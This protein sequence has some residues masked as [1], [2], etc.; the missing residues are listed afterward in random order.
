M[1]KQPA[2]ASAAQ[3]KDAGNALFAKKDYEAAND[4]YTEALKLDENNAVLYANRSAC[5]YN[6][7]RYLDAASDANR[8]TELDPT[9]AKAWSRLAAAYAAIGNEIASA[10]CWKKALNALPTENLTPGEKKQKDQYESEL[11][12]MQKKADKLNTPIRP[13]NG[14]PVT[15]DMAPWIRAVMMYPGMKERGVAESSAYVI[16]GA[17]HDWRAGMDTMNNQRSLEFT[18]GVL[19]SRGP[20]GAV[21]HFSNAILRDA[22]IFHLPD[23]QWLDTYREQSLAE[24]RTYRAWT[25]AGPELVK[26]EALERLEREGW[27]SLRPALAV[28]IRTWIFRGFMDSTVRGRDDVGVEF[29]GR[30][31]EI[32]RWGQEVWKD[33]HKDNRGAIFVPSFARGVHSLYLELYLGACAKHR[34]RFPLETLHEEAQA[35]L[36]DCEDVAPEIG[37]TDPGFDLAYTRYPRGR[38]YCTIGWYHAQLASQ[39]N[40][41]EEEN[42]DSI[43]EHYLKS[44]DAYIQSANAF[45]TDDI[46]HLWY[47]NCGLQNFWR[48]GAP[49][50]VTMPIMKTIRERLPDMNKIWEHYSMTKNG[51]GAFEFTLE[52]EKQF[53]EGLDNGTF[54]MDQ[55]PVPD[56]FAGPQLT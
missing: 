37:P 17:Y 7:K 13:R 54:T 14:G 18:Q 40:A 21:Q 5:F 49:L 2:D 12:I 1:A 27:N 4:K 23:S 20:S 52:M 43:L 53:R 32:I 19:I 22:R 29:V 33:V 16:I 56:E 46:Y 3:L 11:K 31:L 41:E 44:A 42:K 25:Q 38:A 39:L 35:L 15:A 10:K 36:K 28:T 55:A 9:Y 8:A 51:L 6:V 47:M 34:A 26:T 30:A 50:K 24:T 48:C 45:A